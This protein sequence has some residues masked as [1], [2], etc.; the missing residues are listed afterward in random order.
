MVY[1]DITKIMLLKK[2]KNIATAHIPIGVG[3]LNIGI[4]DWMK[5]IKLYFWTKYCDNYTSLSF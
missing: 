2:K 1:D 3:I 4:T 5:Y